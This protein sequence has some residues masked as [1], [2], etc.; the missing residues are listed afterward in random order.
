MSD[1]INQLEIEEL[2]E[3][4]E[5]RNEVFRRRIL[6]ALN[7]TIVRPL[8]P[9]PSP[10][11]LALDIFVP[12]IPMTKGS[13]KVFRRKLIPDNPG[14]PEWAATVGWVARAK[15]RNAEPVKA[16]YAVRI[17]FTLPPAQGRKL[18]R[19]DLD[20][21]ARS[22]FDALEGIVWTNDEQVEWLQCGK[23]RGDTPGARI[24]VERIG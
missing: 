8:V 23:C 1:A 21:L 11:S 18:Y 12:G 20:K 14:E 17:E 4:L 7:A 6:T 19:R 15:L 16:R 5:G 24:I 22:V 2:A 13:W 3:I 10:T 9:A